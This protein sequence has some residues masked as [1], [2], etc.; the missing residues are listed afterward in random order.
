MAACLEARSTQH[1]GPVQ[2]V[3]EPVSRDS[4]SL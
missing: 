3:L 4:A 1:A 2:L